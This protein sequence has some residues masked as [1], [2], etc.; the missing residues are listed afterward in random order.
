[1]LRQVYT[2]FRSAEGRLRVPRE[3]H[4]SL[5]EAEGRLEELRK[6]HTSTCLKNFGLKH[7]MGRENR[8]FSKDS[9]D[10]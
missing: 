7:R 1:M 9:R 5:C 4:T 2:N 6:H 10:K 8:S 3:V